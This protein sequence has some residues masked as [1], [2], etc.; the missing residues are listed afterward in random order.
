MS[1]SRLLSLVIAGIY[2]LIAYLGSKAV[3]GFTGVLGIALLLGL[4]CIWFGDELGGM[5]GYLGHARITSTTPG[6]F[7]R[8]VGW[9]FLV[10]LPI[11]AYILHKSIS[12]NG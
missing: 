11:I 4:A 10:L 3:Q 5:C 8:F 9:L 6:G 2:I 12:Q 7:V 1:I